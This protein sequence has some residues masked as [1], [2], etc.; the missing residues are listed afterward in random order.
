MYLE[1]L[2]PTIPCLIRGMES[3]SEARGGNGVP[4]QFGGYGSSGTLVPEVSSSV[5]DYF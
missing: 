1:P 5:A 4:T 2:F 3:T